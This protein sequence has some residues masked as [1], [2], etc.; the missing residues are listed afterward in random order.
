MNPT[1]LGNRP[2][3]AVAFL[4][5]EWTPGDYLTA[6]RTRRRRARGM[7][8]AEL[9]R[10]ERGTRPSWNYY[11]GV[12]SAMHRCAKLRSGHVILARLVV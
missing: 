1:S 3:D 5:A 10:L 9:Q 2:L 6:I 7:T 4:V 12:L 8:K 11:R